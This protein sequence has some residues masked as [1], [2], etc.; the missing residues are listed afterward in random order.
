MVHTILSILLFLTVLLMFSSLCQPVHA[1]SEGLRY[2]YVSRADSIPSVDASG[3]LYIAISYVGYNGI[4]TGAK[5]TTY[6]QKRTLGIFW[7]KVNNGE[8]DN[9]WV[10]N[11]SGSS[12]NGDHE[13]HLSSTG[14]YRIT[15]E[16]TIYAA[17]GSEP[18]TEFHDRQNHAGCAAAV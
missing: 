1:D 16:F 14:T 11:V 2:S 15:S 17:T 3:Q 10:D 7:I 4:T 8:P 9:E 18:Q 12:Y 13:L 5:I 6:V